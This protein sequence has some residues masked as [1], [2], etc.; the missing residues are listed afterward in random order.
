M[1][2]KC[3]IHVL[4]CI[5]RMLHTALMVSLMASLTGLM[6]DNQFKQALRYHTEERLGAAYHRRRPCATCTGPGLLALN[7]APTPT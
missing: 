2:V 3:P 1:Y 4:Q 6:G 7:L 5:L